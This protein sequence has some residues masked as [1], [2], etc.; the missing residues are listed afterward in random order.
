MCAVISDIH[1]DRP[2]LEKA[3]E[4]IGRL[5]CDRILC[6]GDIVGYSY[7]YSESLDG[8]DPDACC[9]LVR[10]NCHA[11]ICGNHDLHS[12]ERIPKGYRVL[13]M[14]ENWYRLDLGE[15][16]AIGRNRFW[17]YA[18]ELEH[19]LGE[20]SREYLLSLSESYVIRTGRYG[21]LCTHFIAP[22]IT[23]AT[24]HSP[25]GRNDFKKHLRLLRRNNCLLGLAGHAHTEGYVQVSRN[26]YRMSYFGKGRLI[27]GRQVLI[28]PAI[29]RGGG[30]NGYMI[31]DTEKDEFEAI[32]L[33]TP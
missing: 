2:S 8:R 33:D 26:A 25:A 6:L 19:D 21:I 3:L 12:L 20:A 17:L 9:T 32:P 15:K 27:E 10:E 1:S 23:G 18:D 22:D 29:T 13:G 4:R 24:Q 11:A 30:R 31:I 14:P 16:S 7:H 5:H 28:C